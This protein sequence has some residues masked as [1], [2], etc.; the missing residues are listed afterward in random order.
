[1]KIDYASDVAKRSTHTN[2]SA[3]AWFVI[4]ISCFLVVLILLLGYFGIHEK[5]GNNTRSK[6][7][8][9]LQPTRRPPQ[10]AR[11][12]PNESE[13]TP[14]YSPKPVLPKAYFGQ[15]ITQLGPEVNGLTGGLDD[16]PPYSTH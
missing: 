15:Q 12:R 2:L 11:L 5:W 1:M 4:A 16:P 8:V 14:L 13:P 9:T 3:G 10:P 6:R 7:L